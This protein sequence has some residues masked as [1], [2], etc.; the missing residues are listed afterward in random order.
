M[1]VLRSQSWMWRLTFSF[2][3]Y[4][5]LYNAISNQLNERYNQKVHWISD[6]QLDTDKGLLGITPGASAGRS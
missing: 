4:D 3:L 2:S 1:A 5:S 6:T